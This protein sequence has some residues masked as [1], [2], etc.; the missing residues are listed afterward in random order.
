MSFFAP[1]NFLYLW[2]LP[3]LIALFVISRQIWKKRLARLGSLHLIQQK[4]IPNYRPSE[5]RIRLILS[6]LALL[7]LILALARPQWGEEK[8]KIQRKGVDIIFMLDTSLSML[9]E[10]IKPSRFE[11]SKIEIR[12]IIKK[13]KGDRIGMVAFAGS[14]FLQ[15]P[16]TLDYSAFF[17]FLDAIKVGYI[18]DPG[19]S[20]DRA[21][22]LAVRSFPEKENKYKAVI[23]FSDGEDQEGGIEAALE[24]AKKS[25]VRIYTIGTGTAQGEPIPLKDENRKRTGFKKDRSGQIVITKL[26]QDLLK[27]VAQETGGIY[28]PSTPSEEEID[29]LMRHMQS[30]GKKEFKEKTITE[31]EDHFQV[32]LLIGFLFLVFEMLVRKTVR[33]KKI[34]TGVF[35]IVFM[36]LSLFSQKAFATDAQKLYTE[37][38]YNSAKE[39]YE[40]EKTK[41]PDDPALRYNLGTTLYQVDEF[42]QASQELENSIKVTQDPK[43]KAKAYYNYGNTQYRL[44]KFDE[45]MDSYKKALELNPEDK[46]A[47]YNLELLQQ[48][49]GQFEKNNAERQKQ[50]QKQNQQNKNQQQ[51]QQNQ[52]NQ[53][54]NQQ[55]Q[56]NQQQNQQSQQNQQQNQ[57]QQQQNPQNQQ[58]QQDSRNQQQPQP[59]NQENQ[60]DQKNQQD[61]GQQNQK[62][63]QNQEN[64]PQNQENQPPSDE[65]ADQG[66]QE[67][68]REG[69]DQ[70]NQDQQPQEQS[71][72]NQQTQSQPEEIGGEKPMAAK[73]DEGKEEQ[74][75]PQNQGQQGRQ[76]LQGQMSMQ[77]A[78]QLLDALKEGEKELQDLRRP[79]QKSPESQPP[80]KDW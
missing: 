36:L 6:A 26:N 77:N 53:Q 60:Q 25:G 31:R 43:L 24:E 72:K 50:S 33:P 65:K 51:N 27:T 61:K 44:G 32:F 52:K 57:N 70:Q 35:L 22:R 14:G 79:N 55:N 19:T 69:S 39:I 7:F 4:L 28:L 23:L 46:D 18:P 37:K 47:K 29:I 78:L 48:K 80:V 11:K 9:S 16:L 20:L 5:H 63:Q 13:L 71:D 67:E 45:A 15:S 21:I 56:Q 66:K 38:K 64:Q 1:E 54:N 62:N 8:R 68:P 3:V 58:D 12:N 76:P 49:K 59:D 75:Q 41:N 10:D 30:L 40:K 73:Q 74:D 2:T 34:Q 17:L 42:G